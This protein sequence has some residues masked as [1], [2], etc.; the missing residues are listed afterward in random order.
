MNCLSDGPTHRTLDIATSV[1]VAQHIPRADT[2]WHQALLVFALRYVLPQSFHARAVRRYGTA[3]VLVGA[4]GSVSQKE[5][6]LLLVPQ[7]LLPI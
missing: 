2:V 5:Q 1:I 6:P 7:N 3:I 4:L